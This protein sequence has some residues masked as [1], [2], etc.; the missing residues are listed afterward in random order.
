MEIT[1]IRKRIEEFTAEKA[2]PQP[3][4][5]PDFIESHKH[6][7]EKGGAEEKGKMEENSPPQETEYLGK[8]PV[9]G[10]QINFLITEA[11]WK[12]Y[13]CGHGESPKDETES[14]SV[15]AA[16]SEPVPTAEPPPLL[17]SLPLLRR[18]C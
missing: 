11:M 15:V 6:E 1:G 9:C 17:R 7:E 14:A 18:T 3:M 16:A 13:N 12:C 8:C 5:S 4:A 2:S 10:G